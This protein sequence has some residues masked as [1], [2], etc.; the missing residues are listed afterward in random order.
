MNGARSFD[1]T[2]SELRVYLLICEEGLSH[3]EIAKK[4]GYTYGALKTCI[5]RI[6]EKKGAANRVDLVVKHWKG[7]QLA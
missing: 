6:L 5:H 1:L 2:P 4:V 3:R 7:K